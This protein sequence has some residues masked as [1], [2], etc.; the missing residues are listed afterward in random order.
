MDRLREAQIQTVV[1]Y[2]PVHAF[3]FYR[4]RSPSVYL[5]RTEEFAQRELTLPLHPRLEERHVEMVATALAEALPVGAVA[6]AG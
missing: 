3:S 6:E 4:K 2:P 1:H 5:P